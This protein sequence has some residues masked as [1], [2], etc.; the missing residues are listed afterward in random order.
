VNKYEQR[1]FFFG[2][3]MLILLIVGYV[4]LGFIIGGFGTLV[5]AGGEFLLIPVLLLR[6]PAMSPETVTAISMTT[7]LHAS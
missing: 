7:V 6:F 4:A 1:G 2:Y 5:G 3:P